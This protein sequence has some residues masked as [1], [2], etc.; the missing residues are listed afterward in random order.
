[1]CMGSNT[2]SEYIDPEAFEK[3]E[4]GRTGSENGTVV[5]TEPLVKGSQLKILGVPPDCNIIRSDKFLPIFLESTHQ[6]KSGNLKF[7]GRPF[8]LSGTKAGARA[9]FIIVDWRGRNVVFIEMKSRSESMDDIKCQLVGAEAVLEYIRHVGA[10]FKRIKEKDFIGEA[11][12]RH[13]VVA[14]N[15]DMKGRKRPTKYPGISGGLTL[16]NPLEISHA[17]QVY[18]RNLCSLPS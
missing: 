4:Y 11:F 12:R 2:L 1:M 8:F 10:R 14:K 6:T 18:F 9:D 3:I 16:D 17:D 5:L 13:F 7:N 15:T